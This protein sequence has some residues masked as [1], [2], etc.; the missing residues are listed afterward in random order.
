MQSA[1]LQNPSSVKLDA[2][3]HGVFDFSLSLIDGF[4]YFCSSSVNFTFARGNTSDSLR[5]TV[6]QWGAWPWN[7]DDHPEYGLSTYNYHRD[8]SGIAYASRRRPFIP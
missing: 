1:R 4:V 8:G 7:A 3:L 6:A 5:R 2:I